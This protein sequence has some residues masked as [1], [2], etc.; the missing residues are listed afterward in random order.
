MTYTEDVDDLSSCMP[1]G[2]IN[3][4]SFKEIRTRDQLETS[5]SVVVYFQYLRSWYPR[6]F[7]VLRPLYSFNDLHGLFGAC[8]WNRHIE[9]VAAARYEPADIDRMILS[10]LQGRKGTPE[11][12][13]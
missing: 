7:E 13:S 2:C 8:T 5:E 11:M 4:D 10:K 12:Q 1:V 3:R 9:D 6:C